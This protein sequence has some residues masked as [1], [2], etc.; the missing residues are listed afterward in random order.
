MLGA[1]TATCRVPG[2]ATD[3]ERT[4]P[5]KR[6]RRRTGQSRDV[7]VLGAPTFRGNV[8]GPGVPATDGERTFPL[9][10]VRCRT[11]QSRDGDVA[12]RAD[13]SAATS[14]V[15]GAATD[16]ERTF[17]LKRVQCPDRQSRDGAGP[18]DKR[19]FG[20][21]QAWR[22]WLMRNRERTAKPPGAIASRLRL[23]AASGCVLFLQTCLHSLPRLTTH[24]SPQRASSRFVIC[25]EQQTWPGV[26]I[27]GQSS[28]PWPGKRS[29]ARE[30]ILRPEQRTS[31]RSS[32]LGQ[33]QQSSARSS[34]PRRGSITS[35]TA[36]VTLPAY[37]GQSLITV[38]RL[39]PCRRNARSAA[40]RDWR[41]T[42]W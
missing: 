25:Q 42:R 8:T 3:G 27:P 30:V 32:N 41:T 16:G 36:G 6:V 2:P 28:D 23:S 24:G 10:R 18:E 39:P 20:P 9:K 31:S 11:G 17:P 15:P 7:T 22:W 4:F 35:P 14:R 29:L 34:N 21:H 13:V 12:W 38:W 26:A 40:E 19:S 5:L 33:E 1:P 37:P